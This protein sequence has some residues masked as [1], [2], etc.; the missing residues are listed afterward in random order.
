M[1]CSVNWRRRKGTRDRDKGETRKK[2]E[3]SWLGHVPSRLWLLFFFF[4]EIWVKFHFLP[5]LNGLKSPFYPLKKMGFDILRSL[6]KFRPR[7]LKCR[8]STNPINRDTPLFKIFSMHFSQLS[9]RSNQSHRALEHLGKYTN[10]NPDS[11][12]HVEKL[13]QSSSNHWLSLTFH[14][15]YRPLCH[16][17]YDQRSIMTCLSNPAH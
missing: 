6:K 2:P 5:S 7:N 17:S 13:T 16:I 1:S 4:F 15:K 14:H 8:T 11:N 3:A 9:S 10:S 12:I